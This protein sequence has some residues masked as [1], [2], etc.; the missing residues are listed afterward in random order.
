MPRPARDYAGKAIDVAADDVP[1][2]MTR[3][4]VTGQQNNVRKQYQRTDADTEML[5][6]C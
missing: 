5:A 4:G 6:G 1:E 2:R 3:Q